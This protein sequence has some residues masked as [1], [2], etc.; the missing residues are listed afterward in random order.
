M[1]DHLEHEERYKP[2]LDFEERQHHLIQCPNC[3]HFVSAAE[4]NI[5]KTIAKCSNC[6]HVFNFAH[7][8][9]REKQKT[10]FEYGRPEML[11]P[12]GL[13]VLRLRSELDIQVDWWKTTKKGSFGF[14][15]FFTLAWNLM[16]LPVVI[17]AIAAGDFTI[18]LFTSVHLAV[19]LSLL[20]NLFSMFFNKTSVV[21]TE[22]SLEIKTRPLPGLFKRSKKI[23]AASIDQLY[24]SR[25]VASRTNGNPNYS[26]ALYAIEK[27]GKKTTLIKGMNR[28]TQ[29]YLE[30]AIER[31]LKIKD[32]RIRGEVGK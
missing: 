30:S 9:E 18:P 26:Y 31:F 21:V 28:A 3:E 2:T 5:D 20:Y 29:Q 8:F 12:E 6:S 13:E 25:Y 32:R 14:L 15:V 7:E 16:L 11:I 22:R 1:P 23:D 24:V 4:I 10:E 17:S 27:N 19:G